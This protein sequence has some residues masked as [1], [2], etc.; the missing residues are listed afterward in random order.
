VPSLPE[1]L[2]SVGV[3][4]HDARRGVGHTISVRAGSYVG[5]HGPTGRILKRN[6]FELGSFAKRILFFVGESQRHS[7]GQMVSK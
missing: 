3:R 7:H 2:Q 6:S 1:S 5:T 4:S